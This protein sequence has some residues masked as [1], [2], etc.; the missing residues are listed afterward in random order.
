M[1]T[2]AN[3]K[4][5]FRG[6]SDAGVQVRTY[7]A[8]APLYIHAKVIIA[9]NKEAFVGSENFSSTSLDQNR[10]LGIIVSD[11][12]VVSQLSATFAKD[13]QSAAPFSQ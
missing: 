11:P 1:T 8:D 6:L 4:D 7:P 2:A 3:W 5:A 10:E 13:W 12:A 9:D